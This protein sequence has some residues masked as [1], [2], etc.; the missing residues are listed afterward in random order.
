M[1]YCNDIVNMCLNVIFQENRLGRFKSKFDNKRI[2]RQ[3]D[4]RSKLV[5]EKHIMKSATA[6]G[7]AQHIE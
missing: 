3:T 1:K 5:E 7:S 4:G 6:N 2:A